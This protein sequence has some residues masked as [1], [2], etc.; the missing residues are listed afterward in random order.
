MKKVC[1]VGTSLGK[2]GAERSTAMLSKILFDLRYEV[3]IV[4]TKSDI[5][6]KYAGN[7]FDLEREYGGGLTSFKKFK[8]LRSFFK[9]HN[10][11]IIIDNRTRPSFLKEYIL[12]NYIFLA[13][14]KISLVRSF[15]LKRYFPSSKLL[16]KLIYNRNTTLV[17]VSKEIMRSIKIN[18][19]L[20]N[21]RQIYNPVDINITEA[22][23]TE[24]FDIDGK[25]I[26]WYGRI[27][28]NVKNF[29]LL[30]NAY[31]KSILLT[32]N[33]KLCIIG[34]GKD[35]ELL[36]EKI[37]SLELKD[38]VYYVPFLKNPFPYVKR[39]IYTTL[40]SYY[41]GFPRVLIES[42]SYGT[43]VISV[44]CK[45]GPNEIIQN[46]YNGLLVENHNVSALAN[47]FDR[48]IEDNILYLKCKNNAKTS[49]EK[50]SIENITKDWRELLI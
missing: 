17:A 13:K 40:T 15:Y 33:I 43:P 4:I 27:E 23:T 11:D 16:S 5:D 8:I 44:N 46:E 2:G 45:S 19:N 10:F 29:D 25:F 14:R 41:E 6:Y 36:H 12:Y 26:L 48:M 31:K 37:N 49:V 30:L 34:Q 42:L 1:V 9:H 22:R 50:F 20:Q 28:N 21:V 38:R 35:V 47:A 24:H 7:L 32:K 3:Y 39:A 18:Y